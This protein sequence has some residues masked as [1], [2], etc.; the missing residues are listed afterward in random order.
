MVMFIVLACVLWL[1]E[2]VWDVHANCKGCG[3]NG[4]TSAVRIFL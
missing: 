4:V 1:V 3:S 2:V